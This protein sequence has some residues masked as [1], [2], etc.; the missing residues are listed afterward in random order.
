[1]TSAIRVDVG[2]LEQLRSKGCL[3]AKAGSRPIC[4]FWDGEAA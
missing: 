2:T 1:M 3:T 4:V